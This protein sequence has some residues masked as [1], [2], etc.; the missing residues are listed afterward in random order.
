MFYL[1]LLSN[2]KKRKEQK[3][4][5]RKFTDTSLY[6]YIGYICAYM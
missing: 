1:S 2:S 4:K 5:C 6:P 3:A